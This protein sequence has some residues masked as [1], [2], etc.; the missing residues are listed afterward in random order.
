MAEKITDKQLEEIKK[1]LEAS[2]IAAAEV[3]KLL[4]SISNYAS[5]E[6][7]RSSQE[8]ATR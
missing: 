7:R 5:Q 6:K 4:K 3:E 8:G 2:G 1:G